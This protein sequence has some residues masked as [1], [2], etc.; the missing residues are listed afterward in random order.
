[1]FF[2]GAFSLD[3]FQ[4][5]DGKIECA[6]VEP[7]GQK[8]W[9]SLCEIDILVFSTCSIVKDLEKHEKIM[10]FRRPYGVTHNGISVIFSDVH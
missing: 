4:H 10:T 5:S 3:S 2:A 6:L 8:Q 9:K 7:K 1:M